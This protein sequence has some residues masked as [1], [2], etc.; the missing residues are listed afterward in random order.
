VQNITNYWTDADEVNWSWTSEYKCAVLTAT[1]DNECG[2]T[3]RS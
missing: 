3:R 2:T 1:L